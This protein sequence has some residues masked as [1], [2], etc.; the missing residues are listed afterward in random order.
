RILC[1]L[2]APTAGHARIFG[3]DVIGAR[4]A[5]RRAI[6]V[7]FQSPALDR[8][9]TSRENLLHHG[10][11]YGLRGT[12]LSARID[13][14]LRAMGVQDRTDAL[15]GTLSGGLRRRVEIAKAMLTAPRM[16]MLDEPSTGLDPAARIDLWQQ[17]ARL[18]D[19]RGVT[20]LIITH[21]LDEAERCDK[22]AIMDDGR[23]V[24][25][26]APDTLKRAVGAEV[27]TI[28]AD[29]PGRARQA[30]RDRLGVDAVQIE[31]ALRIERADVA[32]LA[33][34]VIEALSGAIRS[35]SIARPT[36][37]DVYMNLTGRK[38]QSATEQ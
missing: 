23:I 18:R 37:E 31:G 30:L 35:L 26:D 1:T 11:L 33:P 4:D 14:S 17:L 13:S 36:L 34:R 3:Q 27:I 25:S 5:V 29:D 19:E 8:Q 15:V 38:F 22:V 32:A 12:E 20:I 10:H 21:L 6:G 9:L 2:I 7:V 16:L 28:Q 24:A